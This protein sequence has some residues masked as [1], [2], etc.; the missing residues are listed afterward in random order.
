MNDDNQ[1]SNVSIAWKNLSFGVNTNLFNSKRKIILQQLNG[2]LNYQSLNGFL[3]PSGSGK[4]TLL[5]CLN[6]TLRT[7]I[8]PFSRIYFNQND[9]QQ[10]TPVIRMIEQHVHETIIGKMTIRQV[11]QYA[12]RFKNSNKDA[13]KMDKHIEQILKELL[14]DKSILDNRF[15]KCS[16]G[17]QKRVAIAQELMSLQ[18]PNFLFLDEPT[19]G[20]DS[21]SALLVMQCLRRLIDHNNNHLTILVSIHAPNSELLNLF[22]QLYILAKGGVCIYF[23]RPENL[24]MK[25]EQD[26]NNNSEE[27]KKDR[28]AIERYL[29]IACKGIDDNDVQRMANSNLEEQRDKSSSMFEMEKKFEL[30]NNNSKI[31]NNRKPFNIQDFLLQLNRMAN[32]TFITGRMKLLKHFLTFLSFSMLLSMLF[33]QSIVRP[34]TC[35]RIDNDDDYDYES[36]KNVTCFQQLEDEHNVDQYRLYLGMANTINGFAIACLSVLEFMSLIRIFRNEHRNQWYSLGTFY[37][38]FMIIKL[39]ELALISGYITVMIYFFI[40]HTY[41]DDNE[42]NLNR[43]AHFFLFIMMNNIYLQSYGFLFGSLF[44]NQEIVLLITIVTI[45]TIQLFNGVMFSIERMKKPMLILISDL[46]M[47]TVTQNGLMY[48]FYVLDRCDSEKELSYALVDYGIDQNL[49]YK[50]LIKIMAAILIIRGASLLI[51]L[52]RFSAPRI[53]LQRSIRRRESSTRNREM[54]AIDFNNS[55]EMKNMKIDLN[56]ITRQ[57]MDKEIEFEQFSCGKILIAWRSITLFASDSIY[58]IRSVNDVKSKTKLILRNLNGQFRFGTLNAVMGPSGAGKTSL[59]KVLNG[60]MKTRLSE[61]S[62]FYLSKYCPTR[63]CYLTQEVSG[64]LMP[65]LTTLQSLIYASRLKNVL[66]ESIVNHESIAKNI[67]N[68]LGIADTADTYVQKCSGGERKRLALG[69]ELTSLHMPNLI[70]IDEPTSGL[71]SNSAEVVVAC[72]RKLARTH[73]LTI[74]MSIHQPNIEILMM[75]DQ[76]YVL[77]KGGVCV[78]SGKPAEI[79]QNLPLDSIHE[80]RL[81]PIDR[82]MKYSCHNYKDSLVQDLSRSID[83]KI[84]A[85]DENMANDTVNVIDGIPTQRNRF[86]LKSCWILILRYITFVRGYQWIFFAVFSYLC[87]FQG[88]L[89]IFMFDRQMIYTDGCFNP[90]DDL[91]TT[92]NRT[93]ED[94]DEVFNLEISFRYIIAF[95]NICISI[96]L[97]QA[98]FL[99]SK[100]IIYFW[101]EFRNGWYSTGAF[102]LPRIT[103]EWM[104]ILTMISILVYM[105]DIYEEI[106]P[107]IYLW[108]FII[109]VLG[110]ISTQGIGNLLA[111]LTTGE[112]TILVITIPGVVVLC[113]L[114]GNTATP[115]GQL[116]YFYQFL[117]LLS[118]ARFIIESMALLQYGFNRCHE[119][120]IQITLYQL[121]IHHDEHFNFCIIM[122]IIQCIFYHMVAFTLIMIK[123]NP[124]ESRKHRAKKIL[125]FHESMKRS[126]VYIPGLGCDHHF[127]IRRIEI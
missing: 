80:N 31:T 4:T 71:D 5:N 69:L 36:K 27:M 123:S 93:Q 7:G 91:N 17:E 66:E 9:E 2:H 77:A 63:I 99:F 98:S 106:L 29:K 110:I 122:L 44:Y 127:V 47:S 112:L 81:L 90:E 68:E 124:F 84:L 59:L 70:C 74:I 34:D 52:I 92:C 108:L 45:Q 58:E 54:L 26:I 10:P 79:Q 65:G 1:C 95:A 18:Q 14:L 121:R 120:E 3:G 60:Q 50:N 12:F 100:D 118:P 78:Y 73:N 46:L 57:K 88:L 55:M 25:L 87:I 72:L 40:D 23:D 20:L 19:T 119:K 43:L 21:N 83:E 49:I 116:H 105:I 51:M 33:K 76:L 107:G 61:E 101:N 11:L 35:Y 104:L 94:D 28:P 125:Q 126:N 111:I 48:S 109:L 62:R 86:T 6:G 30:A 115:I 8:S 56:E 32:L 82:L 96:F 38:S 22:D 117:S 15:E 24:E 53:K 39:I 37:W 13:S 103:L 41:V 113:V 114:L 97:I 42:I 89:F 85:E 102:Y 75:L 16:G 64:H 67:L